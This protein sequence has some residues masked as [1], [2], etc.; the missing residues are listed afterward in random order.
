MSEFQQYQFRT[1]DQPLTSE[2]RSRIGSLSSR[3]IVNSNSATFVYHYSD[4]R[5]NPLQLM[6]NDFDAMLYVTNWDT[7]Q[8]M[9]RFPRKLVDEQ[10][11]LQYAIEPPY[12]ED[13]LEFHL[14]KEVI[15]MEFTLNNEEDSGWLEEDDFDLGDFTSLRNDIINGDYR[16]LYLAWLR[17]AENYTY[18]E[19][20]EWEEEELELQS[21]PIPADLKNITSSL[22]AFIN[23][24]RV[25]QDIISAAA[26][27]NPNSAKQN[28]NYKTLLDKLSITEKEDFLLRIL[29]QQPR[30]DLLLKK[31]LEQ[32]LSSSPK[33]EK[34]VVSL[35]ELVD[36]AKTEESKRLK[37]EKEERLKAHEKRMKKISSEKEMHWGSV[38]FNLNRKTGKSYDL[39]TATLK[40]LS[41]MYTFEG[42][43]EEFQKK[44]NPIIE[45]TTSQALLRR[46]KGMGL[47]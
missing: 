1:I 23:S 18:I 6:T 19:T 7:R 44:L 31:R 38:H 37:R 15:I 17:V 36:S 22:S 24:F 40:D 11:I 12:A 16:M 20:D 25:D 42:Q 5:G 21:P 33:P 34:P 2:Q 46:F 8:L 9:F 39:A 30:I 47:I 32:F 10:A 4:F 29:N 27:K 35:N 13:S 14:K 26:A 41:D 3:S 45:A 43:A 28:I